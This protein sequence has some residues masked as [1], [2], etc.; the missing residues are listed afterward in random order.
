MY[1]YMHIYMGT[2]VYIYVYIF[3]YSKKSIHEKDLAFKNFNRF[4]RTYS[5]QCVVAQIA[6]IAPDGFSWQ[7]CRRIRGAIAPLSLGAPADISYIYAAKRDVF[8]CKKN[9]NIAP[10]S[11]FLASLL[12]NSRSDCT[13]F[14]R[15]AWG[16]LLYISCEK[17]P[18]H[19]ERTM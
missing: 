9:Y 8:I 6:H 1:T 10:D 13:A 17:K 4:C 11:F 5:R 14:A 2:F 12:W 16:Y 3:M 7:V 18:I 15:C 19:V